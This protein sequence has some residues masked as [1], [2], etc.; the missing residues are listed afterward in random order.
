MAET[1]KILNLFAGIGGNRSLWGDS[2]EITAVEHNSQIAKI[3]QTRFPHDEM[4]VDK[5][6]NVI[7]RPEFFLNQFDLITVGSPC[8][9]HSMFNMVY[10][11]RGII[12][13]P[14]MDNLYG[15]MITLKY[16]PHQSFKFVCENVNPFYKE[17]RPTQYFQKLGR[18]FFWSN[19]PI[20]KKE[21]P[22]YLGKTVNDLTV[23]E[24][25]E[26]HG[27]DFEW[28]NEMDKRQ[29]LRNC[30]DKKI[31]KYILDQAKLKNQQSLDFF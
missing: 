11:S 20:Q 2:H 6:I 30:V 10:W 27:V 13:V 29:I 21:F 18:H 12:K 25:I 5:C 31:G 1:M 16:Y 22:Q 14:D 28:D 15:I 26:W 4:I 17:W 19:F 9:S 8:Q 23:P 24:L 7:E 3:Y